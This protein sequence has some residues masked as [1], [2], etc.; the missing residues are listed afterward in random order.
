MSTTDRQTEAIDIFLSDSAYSDRCNRSVAIGNNSDV[1]F[2]E[3]FWRK[4]FN[5][6]F[7]EIFLKYLKNFEIFFGQYTHPF[8]IFL[9]SN[10]T[11]HSFM[12]T[13]AR[14]V[15]STRVARAYSSS[16]KLKLYFSAQILDNF[17]CKRQ[18]AIKTGKPLAQTFVTQL[19]DKF[20]LAW[21]DANQFRDCPGHTVGYP[22]ND[23]NELA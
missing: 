10:N 1:K 6:I 8:N 17:F 21:D 5:E 20:S 15:P 22:G 16:K 7:R 11:F 9:M 3:I 13:T 12:H 23:Y 2:H 18:T 4:I 19:R 14:A